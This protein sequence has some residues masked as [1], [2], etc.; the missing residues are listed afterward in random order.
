MIKCYARKFVVH[1]GCV[2]I[3]SAQNWSKLRR[4]NE[5]DPTKTSLQQ[6]VELNLM[7]VIIWYIVIVMVL[8]AGFSL[9]LKNIDDFKES[10]GEYFVCE[11]EGSELAVDCDTFKRDY[12]K[13][14][15]PGVH[16]AGFVLFTL[17]PLGFLVYIVDL[18][19]WICKAKAISLHCR[20]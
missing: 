13:L 15:N 20:Q 17:Y 11:S 4:D 5:S 10:V 8:M 1:Y 9:G 16:T 6:K 18:K 7:I 19:Q 14:A 2:Y 3:F 12:E